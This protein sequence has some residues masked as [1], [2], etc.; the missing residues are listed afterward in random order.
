LDTDP[1]VPLIVR[2]PVLGIVGAILGGGAVMWGG[3][4]IGDW[5]A[6]HAQNRPND[7]G[8][9]MT[10][11]SK[12]VPPIP[13]INAPN[14]SGIIAPNNS[15]TVTQTINHGPPRDDMKFYQKGI[16]VATVAS[17][18]ITKDGHVTI[19]EIYN[20]GELKISEPV[21]FR[22]LVIK[23]TK[24]DRSKQTLMSFRNGGVVNNI[25]PDIEGMVI[26]TR[27]P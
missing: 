7:G 27:K 2:L 6:A 10:E 13:P 24:L 21:E 5:R 23:I 3:Y 20:S 4:A 18:Q 1:E 25:I 9:T 17:G 16:A 14:N 19:S 11:P 12:L 22:E 26:G 15:G 8:G